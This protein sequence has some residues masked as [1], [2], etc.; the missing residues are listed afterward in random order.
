LVV[1]ALLLRRYRY[2]AGNISFSTCGW[3]RASLP[4]AVASGIGAVQARMLILLLDAHLPG[5]ALAMTGV[6]LRV[7]DTARLPLLA[8][9]DTL[10]PRMSARRS[11]SNPLQQ[12]WQ[13]VAGTTL[14]AGMVTTA[15][16]VAGEAVMVMLFGERYQ[17]AA[18]DLRWLLLAFV[19][20]SLHTALSLVCY[21]MGL[22]WAANAASAVVITGMVTAAASGLE[23]DLPSLVLTQVALETLVTAALI[24][25]VWR[26]LRA[27]PAATTGLYAPAE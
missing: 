3:L 16:L 4:F 24:W 11:T 6:A 8:V 19:P 22:E 2:P 23:R 10:Y 21:A 17:P 15:L 14:Y 27:T 7:L 26:R 18:D 5:A 12:V 20:L 13:V 25:I 9:F 1:S